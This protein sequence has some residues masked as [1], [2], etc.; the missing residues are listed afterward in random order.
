MDVPTR[1]I[2][3][4]GLSGS[5]RDWRGSSAGHRVVTG[6]LQTEP[7]RFPTGQHSPRGGARYVK[8]NIDW[9]KVQFRALA[10]VLKFDHVS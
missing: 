10:R 7:R 6:P 8:F 1:Q 9:A 3:P 2:Y 5:D 4:I